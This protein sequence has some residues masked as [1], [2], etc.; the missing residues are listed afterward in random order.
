MSRPYQILALTEQSSA[1]WDWRRGG[2]GSSDAPTI[3]GQK[4]AKSPERLLLEK[5]HLR[6]PSARTFVR[7]Q[8]VALERAARALYNRTFGVDLAPACVQSIARPWQRASLDGLSADGARVVEIKCGQAAYQRAKARGRPPP[9]HYAQLQH[10]LSVTG[11]SVVSYWC[12]FPPRPPVHL[13][14]ARDEVYISRLL[15]AEELF[16][17][18]FAATPIPLTQGR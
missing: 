15:V 12:Y 18:R 9:H 5:Q 1:W 6:E 16:W 4:P 13:E 14:V 7:E 3:L 8:G 11:L 17:Q 2:I 10:I